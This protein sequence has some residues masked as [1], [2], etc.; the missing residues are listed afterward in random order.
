MSAGRRSD[1][2]TATVYVLGQDA[3]G[4]ERAIP[5]ANEGELARAIE[6]VMKENPSATVLVDSA[7]ELV[8][9]LGFERVFAL[10][11][12]L[13]EDVSS[14]EG[15]SV[16]VLVNKKAHESRVIEAIGSVAN[17]FID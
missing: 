15:A 12:S 9:T 3:S 13:S 1:A 6:A 16:V 17:E 8:Y 7:T 14:H 11:R 5:S 4:K 2:V 10:L